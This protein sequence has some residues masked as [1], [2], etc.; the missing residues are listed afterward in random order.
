MVDVAMD[1]LSSAVTRNWAM[2]SVVVKEVSDMVTA[3]VL[4]G[5]QQLQIQ[6]TWP[7]PW[8]NGQIKTLC[9]RE[10]GPQLRIKN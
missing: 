8:H 6:V 2:M 9:A 7:R 3:N 10:E 1:G 5:W 4:S